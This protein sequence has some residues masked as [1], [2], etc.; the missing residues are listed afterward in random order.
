MT[1]GSRDI[2]FEFLL[3]GDGLPVF[4]LRAVQI[5]LPFQGLPQTLV[6]DAHDTLLIAHLIH[7]KAA[8]EILTRHE[9]LA[10]AFILLADLHVLLGEAHAITFHAVKSS[11]GLMIIGNGAVW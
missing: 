10:R 5:V 11:N 3:D 2:I 6:G 8:H 1:K 9:D 4:T 7:G